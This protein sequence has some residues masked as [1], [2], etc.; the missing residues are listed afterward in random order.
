MDQ[1]YQHPMRDFVKASA[2]A[3]SVRES[4]AGQQS[5]IHS[6]GPEPERATVTTGARTWGRTITRSAVRY[7][8]A[9]SVTTATHLNTGTT[10][11]ICST[12]LTA[13][14]STAPN[15]WDSLLNVNVL[16]SSTPVSD[17]HLWHFDTPPD[18][19]LGEDVPTRPMKFRE[20]S[21]LAPFA[22]LWNVDNRSQ[23]AL[24]QPR[25]TL[26]APV[27]N[28]KCE[29]SVRLHPYHGTGIRSSAPSEGQ[30]QTSVRSVETVSDSRHR[31]MYGE[32]P[33]PAQNTVSL[34]PNYALQHTASERYR[35]IKKTLIFE[36]EDATSEHAPSQP[37]RRRRCN[38]SPEMDSDS[39]MKQRREHRIEETRQKRR[40]NTDDRAVNTTRQHLDREVQFDRV[41]STGLCGTLRKVNQRRIEDPPQRAYTKQRRP[42]CEP[43]CSSSDSESSS[44]DGEGERHRGCEPPRRTP[45]RTGRMDTSNAKDVGPSAY[46]AHHIRLRTFDGS[47]NF[48]TFWAH[49]ENCASYNGWSDTDKLAHLKAALVGHAGQVLWDSDTSAVNTLSKL[50]ELLK[51][52]FGGTRQADKHRMELRLRRRRRD[53]TLSDLHRDIRRLMALAHP[54]LTETAR[55]EIACDYFVDALDDPDFALKVRE[56]APTTLDEALRVA[57]QLEA[58]TKE[59]KRRSE[60]SV[61]GMKTRKVDV[62]KDMQ[63]TDVEKR[64][65]RLETSLSRGAQPSPKAA[66]KHPREQ[67]STR[68]EKPPEPSYTQMAQQIEEKLRKQLKEELRAE[69]TAEHQLRPLSSQPLAPLNQVSDNRP[70]EQQW[71]RENGNYGLRTYQPN[72]GYS[73]TFHTCWRCGLPGHLQRNCT[74][75]PSAANGGATE[76][77]PTQHN[78]LNSVI[79][80]SKMRDRANVY[81]SMEINGRIY[82]CLLD[83]GCEYTMM[84]RTVVEK[85]EAA[86]TPRISLC[87]L[88]M[89]LH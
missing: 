56:R 72:G 15:R 45:S 40:S 4:L 47:G 18:T 46:R 43:F 58:W 14:R 67:Y 85:S 79:R 61:Q 63:V 41:S 22:S 19:R 7:G 2:R 88:L 8:T 81:L 64:L 66:H 62:E 12:D 37:R 84:P 26:S 53:K 75:A 59:A 86:V 55:E 80:G 3:D 48:E 34:V 87:M 16:P 60:R 74:Q 20:G 32:A 38:A 39:E 27:W 11:P 13:A 52:R 68:S 70:S 44:D 83:S 31:S 1:K 51:N 24:G 21:T 49:F 69:V 54:S 78:A 73:R 28:P 29:D 25:V 6:A 82:P 30:L 42:H 76:Q 33:P 17:G 65:E 71:A 89:A 36:D 9:P 35:P 77:T 23:I 10:A 50:V 57:F 5:E